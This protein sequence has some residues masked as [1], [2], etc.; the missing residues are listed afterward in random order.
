V[1]PVA[2]VYTPH[3]G[4]QYGATLM[5]QDKAWHSS[6]TFC[7]PRRYRLNAIGGYADLIDVGI[8]GPVSA[9]LRVVLAPRRP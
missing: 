8:C 1:L 9:E 2:A 6:T 3:A 7:A 5:R 4:K